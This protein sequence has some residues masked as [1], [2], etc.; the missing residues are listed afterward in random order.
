[1]SDEGIQGMVELWTWHNL[2]NKF[3]MEIHHINSVYVRSIPVSPHPL[4]LLLLPINLSPAVHLQIWCPLLF[5][6]CWVLGETMAGLNTDDGCGAESST[7][8]TCEPK[9]AVVT[10]F[11]FLGQKIN[12]RI[13][14]NLRHQ[15]SVCFCRHVPRYHLCG[16]S[17]S[18][19]L[20]HSTT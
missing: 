20:G 2:L 4:P 6:T 12:C 14:G 9:V 18:R 3:T 13:F 11:R 5:C 8:F 17:S 7:A 19:L 10:C 16:D 15:V 1:M